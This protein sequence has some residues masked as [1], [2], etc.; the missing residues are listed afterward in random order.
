MKKRLF[1]LIIVLSLDAILFGQCPDKDSLWKRLIYLRDV[2]NMPPAEKLKELLPYEVLMKKCASGHDSIYAFLLQRIG[3]AYFGK[4][5]F[6]RA[7]EYLRQSVSIN[8]S[9]RPSAKL[10]HNIL[11]YFYLSAAYDSLKNIGAK[12][13]ALDSCIQIA[14][15]FKYYSDIS[16]IR[17]MYSRVEYFF[18][19][20]D[21]HRC[22]DYAKM[23]EKF[24]WQYAN[25]HKSNPWEY[26]TGVAHASS[27]LAW[28]I[29]AL[30]K[31][32][33]FK[34]AEELLLNKLD[35]YKKARLKNYLGVTFDQL[36]HIQMH[37]GNYDKALFFLKEQLKYDKEAGYYFNCKQALNTIGHDIYFDFF[38]DDNNALNYYRDALGYLNNDVSF[39]MEDSMESLNIFNRIA[40]AYVRKNSY[41]SA[42][43]Y[44]QLAFDQIKPGINEESISQ[45]P[46]NR[47]QALRKVDFVSTLLIDKGDALKKIYT[48]TGKANSLQKAIQTYKRAD[49]F[50]DAIK[51]GIIDL[52]S[53]LFWRRDAR[54]LYENAIQ[55]CFMQQNVGDAFY[56]F[57]KSRAILLQD[58]LNEQH[59][60][61]ENDILKQ[62]QLEKQILYL[63]REVSP[64][65]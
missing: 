1:I 55:A 20:G 17:S 7:I 62:A 50:L 3:M 31:L 39:N 35:E 16:C 49:V 44:F 54:R 51:N 26:S 65:D 59:W 36:A 11:G 8:N 21:Y 34:S 43:K 6:L 10:Q 13:K 60:Y 33:D 25:S 27:S 63:Q 38:K 57:E 37:K 19:V 61:G 4:S 23:C 29:E 9:G 24:A 56:F 41:D 18:N 28:N 45:L 64:T 53:K 22:I 42:F 15:K 52:Q 48:V 32:G 2:Y 58:Q 47:F 14:G 46:S 5:D 12:M 40:N 30:I